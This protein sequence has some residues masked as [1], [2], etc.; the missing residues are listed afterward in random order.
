MR[1][2]R[3]SFRCRRTAAPIPG[4]NY[5]AANWSGHTGFTNIVQGS[6]SYVTGSHS[7]KVGFRYHSND[8]NYPVNFYNDTQLKYFFQDGVPNQVTVYAD[9]NS[10]QEQKQ[11]MIALYA[12]DRWTLGRLTLQGGLRF[13]HLGDYFP[14]AA[15][16]PNLFLPTAVKFPAQ[17]GPLSQ[18]DLMPRFGASYDVFG[19]GKT[20]AKFFMG[21]YVTTFNTVDEWANYS[22]AGPRAFRHARTRERLDR[23]EPRLRRQLQ[24]A[25]LDRQRR[26]RPGQSV[27]R[28]AGLS[29]DGR[30]GDHERMEHTRVQ[31]GSDAR[32]D[33]ASRAE[34]VGRSS[35]T[36][37]G[38]GETCRPRST[39]RGRRPTSIRSSTTCR[40]IR[41]CP[42]A[43]GTR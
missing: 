42:A 32:R 23:R 34:S 31:L 26:V 14:A 37:G 2:I 1:S 5:R 27:L 33:A 39:A 3:R 11:S 9:A 28:Q 17:D 43:A 41:S 24:P 30:P 13:E 21:R 16:G 19:N 8:A 6:A 25:E 38:A 29:A 22:P 15:D 20:A 4:I 18:K 40:R 12:Q 35:T 10:H 36:S 7:A